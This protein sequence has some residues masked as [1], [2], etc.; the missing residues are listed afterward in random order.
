MVMFV[1]E[2]VTAWPACPANVTR[3]FCPGVAI[4]IDC[5]GP[6]TVSEAEASAGMLYTVTIANPVASLYGSTVSV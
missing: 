2:I 3:P 1:S 5:V 4:E 6:P